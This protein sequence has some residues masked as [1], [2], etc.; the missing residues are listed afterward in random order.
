MRRNPNRQRLDPQK[1]ADLRFVEIIGLGSLWL[2]VSLAVV[3]GHVGEFF[4]YIYYICQLSWGHIA[5]HLPSGIYLI[6]PL[7]MV[8]I[9]GRGIVLF[10]VRLW[11]TQKF[12]RTLTLFQVSSP[13]RLCA[14]AHRAGLGEDSLVCFEASVARAF[15]LGIWHPRIWLST[16]L[17]ALLTDEELVAVLQHEAHHCRQRDPLRLL[18]T[19][20][21]SDIFFF[22]PVLRNLA[23]Y[24]HLAQ[25]MAADARAIKVMGDTLP[26]AS[27]LHKLL[28]RPDAPLPA[29][30]IA[31]SQLNI[32]E[33]RIL[34][35]VSPGQH[36]RWQPSLV[37]WLFSLGLTILLLGSISL[38]RP[39]IRQTTFTCNASHTIPFQ[40]KLLEKPDVILEW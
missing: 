13:P 36:Q 37:H 1:R 33:R 23:D 7:F 15:S 31:I 2:L 26:L 18:I 39:T 35:L 34:A 12:S 28:T 3:W 29:A 9:L 6:I 10:V 27:A 17:L 32:T 20:L 25:E 16:G 5:Q 8:I 19:R 21:I 4:R 38:S 30:G 22:I 24:N 14:L 40:L 11:A